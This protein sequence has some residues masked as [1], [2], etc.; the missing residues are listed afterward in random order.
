[1]T[2][3]MSYDSPS[4]IVET[5]DRAEVR[6]EAPAHT[7]F[8]KITEADGTI[9]LIPFSLLDDAERAIMEDQDLYRQ[10]RAGLKAFQE[11]RGVSS[12][13]LFENDDDDE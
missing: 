13:W 6:I 2:A 7:K 9:R 1:M 4:E 3:A 5:G 10:T 8:V 11:G 12:D